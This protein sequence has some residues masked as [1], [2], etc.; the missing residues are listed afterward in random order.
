MSIMRAMVLPEFG[1]DFELRELPVPEPGPGEVLV[2]VEACGAGLTLE[3]AR[4]GR[5]GGSTPRV[6]GH[7]LGGRVVR[8]GAGVERWLEGDPVTASF[9][10]F[11][12]VCT[13]CS[14]GRETL[15]L[16]NKGYF[17]VAVDGAFAEYV[18]VPARNLVGIPDGVA[19]GEAGVVADAIA[20]PYHV[21]S[22]RA[23]I[24]PGQRVGV[25]GAG[26]G[27]GVHMLQMIRAFGARAVALERDPA[28]LGELRERGAADVVV[29][30][31]ER[32]WER[33][34]VDA[35][36]GPLDVCVDMVGSSET[37]AACVG[38]LGVA[39]TLVVVG[40]TPGARLDV[41]ASRV[42]LEE[43]VLTGNRYASRAEIARCLDL[44]AQGAV[45]PVIGARYPLEELNDAFEAI[46]ANEVFGRL[47]IEPAAV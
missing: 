14:A 6:L 19:V 45:E 1:G 42:L 23:R 46:R 41:D 13:N 30:A 18:V 11:C 27:I 7:E 9:Y 21:A 2:E 15:C 33:A 3:H 8:C 4:S 10:L 17:G 16:D 22:R 29:D 25:L 5:L 36:G 40:L 35:A 43:L 47:L 37:L 26:G 31:G 44:V 38:L 12:G 32:D 24:E 34:A 39:G 20:T 28:K